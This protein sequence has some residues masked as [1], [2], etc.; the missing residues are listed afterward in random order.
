MGTGYELA[1]VFR[2]GIDHYKQYHRLSARQLKVIQDI[3]DCRTAALGGH[4]DA[5]DECGHVRISYNS[6]RN[7]HCPKCQ[8]MAREAWLEKRRQELLPV[9]YFHL[10]F[11]LPAELQDLARYNERLAYDQLFKLAWES[12]SVLTGDKRYLGAQTGMIA[13]LH[14]WGQNLHYHPHIHCLVPAG[15]LT[16]SG[17]WIATRKNYLVPIRALSALFRAK[18]ISFLRKAHRQGKLRLEGL[19][20]QWAPYAQMNR[21]LNQLYQKDWVVYAKEPF[22]GPDK[23]LDYLGRYVKR[24]AISNERILD[25]DE[26]GQR[27]AFRWRDYADQNHLKVMWL[28]CEEFI[29]RFLRHILPKGFSKVRY[30]GLLANRDKGKRLGLCRNTLGQSPK[31]KAV[32]TNWQERFYQLTGIDPSRC[33]CCERG[34]MHTIAIVLPIRAPPYQRVEIVDTTVF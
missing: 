32:Q 26:D 13:V 18:Y 17:K 5:C 1:D 4:V 20:A 3:Q 7:R 6:C 25:L 24:V 14:T 28:S 33:P 27:V 10:V 11:T 21:L 16:P 9:R 30:Y 29:R 31:L 2:A 34:K 12:L 8:S 19:C 15:G 22:A 23:L